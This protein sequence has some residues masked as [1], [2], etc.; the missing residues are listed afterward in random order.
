MTQVQ[1]EVTKHD[2]KLAKSKNNERPQEQI[3][4]RHKYQNFQIGTLRIMFLKV[5]DKME[6]FKE[7]P[8]NYKEKVKLKLQNLEKAHK[9]Q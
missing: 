7:R 1:L 3:H 9:I 4:R 6:N 2:K 8:E 5:H